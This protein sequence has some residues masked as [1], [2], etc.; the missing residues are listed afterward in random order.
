MLTLLVVVKA[1]RTA[2][3]SLAFPRAN[4]PS[5]QTTTTAKH[6]P[7]TCWLQ[8][9]TALVFAWAC[10]P[11][12]EFF[13]QLEPYFTVAGRRT[14]IAIRLEPPGC[15]F[16]MDPLMH[17]HRQGGYRSPCDEKNKGSSDP[18][19]VAPSRARGSHWARLCWTLYACPYPD[20]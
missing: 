13:S 11:D 2:L 1:Q 7:W 6:H 12:G 19:V 4:E 15:V 3:Q 14:A 16:S 20:G 18:M 10:F 8:P 17:R 9:S 5:T